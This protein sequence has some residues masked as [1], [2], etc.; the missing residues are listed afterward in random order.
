MRT[1]TSFD[2]DQADW[3]I[4]EKTEYL[5]TG[6]GLL[7][8]SFALLIDAMNLKNRN[9]AFGRLTAGAALT[10]RVQNRA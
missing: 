9:A 6:K 7:E 5:A 4:G 3:D 10:A 1:G 2:A 8:N